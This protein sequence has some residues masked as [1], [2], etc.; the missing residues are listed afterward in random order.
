M[1]KYKVE[2]QIDNYH[3]LK[4]LDGRLWRVVACRKHHKGANKELHRLE[5]ELKQFGEEYV[6]DQR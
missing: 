2:K 5:N 6:K 3:V 1:I 4:S